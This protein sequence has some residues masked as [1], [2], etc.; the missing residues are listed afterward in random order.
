MHMSYYFHNVLLNV[1]FLNLLNMLDI[2]SNEVLMYLCVY[3]IACVYLRG[4]RLEMK[5]IS[6]L[7]IFVS[8]PMFL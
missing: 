3:H 6:E 2:F 5:I 4:I 7:L 1:L 8:R